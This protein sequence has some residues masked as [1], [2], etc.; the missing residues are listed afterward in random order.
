[1]KRSLGVIILIC[2]M[3][4]LAAANVIELTTDTPQIKSA[5]G[6]SLVEL[7]GAQLYGE[8]GQPALPWLGSSTLLPLG[9]EATNITVRL[10]QPMLFHL[11]NVIEP[12]QRPH[13]LSLPEQKTLIAPDP[14]IY[15][16]ANAWPLQAHNG[17]NTQFLAG[18][19]INFTAVCP[20][21]Y[22]PMRNELVWYQR[23][24]I[25]VESAPSARA[26]AA[27][28]LLKQDAHISQRLAKSIDNH[29]ALPRYQTRTTGIDYL[30]I[31]DVSKYDQWLPLAEFHEQRGL[32]VLMKPVQEITAQ[33]T[34]VDTQEKIRNYIIQIYQDHPL[35]YVLL[36]GDTDVIPHRGLYVNFS[37]GNQVDSDIPADMYYSCLDGNWN[38]N[39]N[40]YWGEPYEADLAPELDLGRICYN[41]DEEI[42]N[43]INKILMYHLAPVESEV[44]SSLFLGEWLWEGPTWGGD[45]MDEMI[46]GSAMNGYTT[47]G[48]PQSWDI[49]T[50]YDRTYGQSDAWG[51]TQVRP[52]LSQGANLVNHLGHSF[53][54]YAMRLSNSQ[55]SA[56]T[57]TNNG[58]NH[59]F[60]I[61]FTQGCYAG[62][63]DNRT[64]NVGD[65]TSDCVTEKLTSIPTA[66]V[67]MISHSRYGWG[68]QNSTNGP[69]QYFHRQYID[70]IFGEN[71]HDLGH[72]LTDS[73]IDNIPFISNSPVMYWVTYE[74]NLFGDPAL[75]IWTETPQNI[76]AQL[77]SIWSMAITNYPIPTNAPFAKLRL[78]S[79]QNIHYEGNADAS[80][81]LQVSFL[82]GLT[83]GQYEVY[84]TAPNFYPYHSMITVQA[85]DMAYIVP[86]NVNH[87]HEGTPLH[88]GDDLFVSFTIKN[89]GNLNLSDGGT[90]NI[91]S[92]S[93]N[94][95]I[96]TGGPITFGD[97]A[98]GDSLVFNNAFQIG[99]RGSFYDGE[100]AQFAITTSFEGHTSTISH[101]LTLNA[102]KI[103]LLSYRFVNPTPVIYPGQNPSITL[104]LKN[105]GSGNAYH[106]FMVLFCDTPG[107]NLSHFEVELPAVYA[108]EEET[109]LSIFSA[110]IPDYL[111][112]NTNIN[113][114][115]IL[116]AENGSTQEG[117]IVIHL[118][119]LNFDFEDGIGEWVT[120]A[121]NP[122][123]TNQWHVSSHRNNTVDGSFSMKFGG[124]G[125]SD[126]ASRAFGA[127]D[128]PE[129]ELGLNSE[130]KFSHWMDAEAHTNPQYAW[131]GGLVQMKLNGADWI[132]I[133]PVGGYPR[134]IYNNPA[135]P[136]AANTQCWSGSFGWTDVTFDLSAYSGTAQFRFLF[137][138]DAYVTGEGWYIDDVRVESEYVDTPDDVVAAPSLSLEAN[139]PNP[140]N[141]STTI[142]FSLPS[143]QNVELAIYNLKGQ[144]VKSLVKSPLTPGKH[145]YI[146]DGKDEEGRSVSS[147]VYLYILRSE[148]KAISRKMM[149]MK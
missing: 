122:S 58:G 23:A 114:G 52:L 93:P 125:S 129:F 91:S 2:S 100:T 80:G 51:P 103:K 133:A 7:K 123:Y 46:G 136:F 120:E 43:Q 6:Y 70:A 115:Y 97:V 67:G 137:G 85:N 66:A 144:R 4:L 138:S 26:M 38:S 109:A 69:S 75:S 34:G 139:H 119:L 118:G 31:H 99:I 131:D 124:Q 71:I 86:T 107:V 11:E 68:M 84:I 74:T 102:P 126:Y 145:R 128:S 142:T 147:G 73:K 36:A 9:E 98:P 94:L 146:W 29:S 20:F 30:I 140:F 141:P 10:S 32:N 112:L 39:G 121:L 83:P 50:L 55:I 108:G 143:A 149:L 24:E 8:P 78:K 41:N 110:D 27:L 113:I 135:S 64:T 40:S 82:S 76:T 101:R 16:S 13:P 42:S 15:Q 63:F 79:G 105:E 134:M 95:E 45:Y 89:I 61:Y 87:S 116:S 90:I 35:R 33:M 81:L 53:T 57:I 28:Q 62:S 44:K 148:D 77:P 19:P 117:N 48:V 106:P 60:S 111:P 37:G 130:L 127:L 12:I 92:S 22:Y 25:E 54:T 59:N 88:S 14:A 1:M 3:A 49:S 56:S 21:E 96:L 65:Y 47:V 18:H 17:A 72:T 104:N 132:Q 5:N